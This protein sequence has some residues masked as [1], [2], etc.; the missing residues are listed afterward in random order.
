MHECCREN[1]NDVL[2]VRM[3]VDSRIMFAKM[4]TASGFRAS[5]PKLRSHIR[6]FV[7]LPYYDGEQGA[8]NAGFGV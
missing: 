2:A 1:R 6:N 4:Q 8:V 7:A 3:Y 5:K